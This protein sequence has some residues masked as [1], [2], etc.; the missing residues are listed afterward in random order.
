[1]SPLQKHVLWFVC[2]VSGAPN[3]NIH[4]STNAFA[5]STAVFVE[6][7]TVITYFVKQSVMTK[8]YLLPVSWLR[9]T[10]PRIPA[11]TF[12]IGTPTVTGCNSA[13][14]ILPAV[15]SAALGLNFLIYLSMS[16]HIMGYQNRC[17]VL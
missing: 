6:R 12:A 15:E 17:R 7:G 1:M 10:G 9:V 2:N 16:L 3:S 8:M 5:T 11:V 4:F 13:F 14:R